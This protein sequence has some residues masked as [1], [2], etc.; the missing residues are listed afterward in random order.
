MDARTVGK[1]ITDSKDQK[2]PS[3]DH[4]VVDHGL[5]VRGKIL[6]HQK[7]VSSHGAVLQPNGDPGEVMLWGDL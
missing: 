5:H 4:G 2:K 3:S 6:P 1:A 7:H